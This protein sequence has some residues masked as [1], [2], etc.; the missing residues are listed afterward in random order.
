MSETS[1]QEPAAQEPEN[2]APELASS[3]NGSGEEAAAQ[4]IRDIYEMAADG[5][6][7]Q[8]YDLV[9]EGLKQ[10]TWHTQE[11]WQTTYDTLESISFLE[12]PDAQVTGDTAQVTA[13]TRA[14]HTDDIER[15]TGSWT[16][17]REDGRWKM[18]S[19]NVREI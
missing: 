9:S 6:Y 16:L 11:D 7:G 1:E 17:I 18:D 15:N 5:N 14:V 19:I 12:G 2:D 3:Q 10:S 13:V 4:T 8:S